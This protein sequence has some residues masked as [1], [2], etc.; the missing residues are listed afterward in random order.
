M[1]KDPK[2]PGN[3]LS[4]GYGFVRYKYKSDAEKALKQLQ[5]TTLDGKTLEL[6][7]SKRTLK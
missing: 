3:Q 4:M 2:N 7:L 5:M 6:K 1:K